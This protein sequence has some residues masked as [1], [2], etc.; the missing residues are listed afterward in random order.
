MFMRVG[1][2]KMVV[3]ILKVGLV[4]GNWFFEDGITYGY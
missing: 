2:L 4:W 1:F 3:F